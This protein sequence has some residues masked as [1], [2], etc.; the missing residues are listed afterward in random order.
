MSLPAGFR[1]GPYE[2]PAPLGAGGMGEVY[3]ARDSRLHRDVAIKVLP[4]SFLR[5]AARLRRF[6]REARGLSAQSSAPEDLGT[7]GAKPACIDAEGYRHLRHAGVGG[8]ESES[9]HRRDGEVQRVE[10]AERESEARQPVAGELIV[11]ALD[12]N[13][14]VEAVF[15]V[16][17]EAKKNL[18]GVFD[19]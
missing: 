18:C 11:T 10:R 16:D 13:S 3:R 9:F 7:L 1:L 4:E 17:G 12:W 14:G 19:G 15:D 8:N 5:D 6:E 2:I